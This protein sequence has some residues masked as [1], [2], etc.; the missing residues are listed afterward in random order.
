MSDKGSSDT[1]IVLNGA[2][3]SI[4]QD[5]R[6]ISEQFN[7]YFNNITK[8]LNFFEWKSKYDLQRK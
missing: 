3:G 7:N 1:R 8:H 6:E 2:N 5:E 4:A